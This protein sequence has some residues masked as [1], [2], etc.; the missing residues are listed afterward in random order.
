MFHS[1]LI[2]SLRLSYLRDVDDPYGPRIIS[3]DPSYQSNPY[4]L[5][6]SMTDV[7]RW[8]Q[9]AMPSSPN[10]SEDEQDRPLGF[11]GARLKHTQTIMGGRTGGLGLRVHGKRAS[12]SKRMSVSSRQLDM[13]NFVSDNAP[14]QQE[15]APAEKVLAQSAPGSES[16][17]KTG[18]KGSSSSSPEPTVEVQ[19]AT[20][21]E[22][23][24]VARVVQFIPKF[25]GAAEME[26]RRRVRMEAR[27]R[28]GA[29]VAQPPPKLDFSSS[30]DEAPVHEPSPDDSVVVVDSMDEGDEFDPYVLFI[31]Y[32]SMLLTSKPLPSVFAA[33]RTG[34][35]SDSA[36]DAMSIFSA[37]TATSSIAVS[38]SQTLN[39]ARPRL[40][41][42]SEH[43][44]R[45]PR[46][47]KPDDGARKR[48]DAPARSRG[49]SS[50]STTSTHAH[51]PSLTQP[52]PSPEKLVV[53][54]KVPPLKPLTSSLSALLASSGSSSNP[55]AEMYATISGRGESAATNV[56]IYFPHARQPQGKAM[57]LNVRRDAT[58]EEVIGFALW[59]YWEK[60]WLPK[61]DEGLAGEDDPKRATRLSAVGWILRIA[62]DDGEVDDDF[63]RTFAFAVL[64]RNCCNIFFL[65]AP[66]RMEKVT[67][68]SEA[69]AILEATPTQ[70]TSVGTLSFSLISNLYMIQSNKTRFWKA[71][72]N[73]G[74]REPSQR[75]QSTSS[76]S[77][78]QL[79]PP[80]LQRVRFTGR[81]SLPVAYRHHWDLH[82]ATGPKY[83]FGFTQQMLCTY[84]QPYP[85]MYFCVSRSKTIAHI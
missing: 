8:P 24:P 80:Q 32:L 21:P 26:A 49:D 6:A 68:F 72:S 18:A 51:S 30:E 31:F 54:R 79:S 70:S 12:T 71:K 3:L 77:P 23:N 83:S 53:R 9:L 76:T 52:P 22:E 25:K 47:P 74:L 57:D 81:T 65:I 19:Q 1:F 28:P 42:V 37:G 4:I 56:Q 84:P 15:T 85:C 35:T 44:G 2:H 45:A 29:P 75:N 39:R 63:P 7:D 67:K 38:S 61:L 69:Y 16:W 34:A 17:V 46:A 48:P 27:R 60:G 10:L 58:V 14:V 11:P 13:K 78:I 62:E 20:A 64:S 40:S 50:T 36:S 5:S 43:T 66:D 55:F 59:S 33:T 41:P 82:P 73:G